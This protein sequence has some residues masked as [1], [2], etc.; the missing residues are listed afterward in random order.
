MEPAAPVKGEMGT[1]FEVI[2]LVLESGFQV[3][4]FALSY[5]T[6]RGTRRTRPAITIERGDVSVSIDSDDPEIIAQAL[7]E[8]GL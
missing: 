7:R 2:K 8:L 4:T 5:V 6:W 1:A 3:A